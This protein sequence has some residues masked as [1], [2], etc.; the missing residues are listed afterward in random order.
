MVAGEGR[1]RG[2]V[3][4][5]GATGGDE[6]RAEL[7]KG[8]NSVEG[9]HGSSE[10]KRLRGG[11]MERLLQEGVRRGAY[12]QEGGQL[13]SIWGRIQEVEASL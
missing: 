9:R 11:N 2:G 1:G 3:R 5:G 13:P 4:S 7:G 8:G 6:N 10:G 12:I